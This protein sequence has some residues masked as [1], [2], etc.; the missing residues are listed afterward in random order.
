MS[1]STRL[2]YL[3]ELYFKGICSKEEEDELFHLVNKAQHDEALKNLM[4]QAWV[5]LSSDYQLNNDQSERILSGILTSF[6]SQRKVVR[7]KGVSILYRSAAAAALVILLA[8]GWF[9]SMRYNGKKELPAVSPLAQ[10]ESDALPGGNKAVLI[11]GNGSS[12]VLDSV[13]N[14]YIVSQGGVQVTKLNGQVS[15]SGNEINTAAPVYNTIITP[16]GGIFRVTLPDNS[17]VWLNASSSL[18]FPTVFNGAERQ[19]ELTGEAYFEIA[20]NEDKPF[21]V[22]V[23]GVQVKVLGTHFNIMAY[24]NDPVVK[25]TLLEGAVKV[26]KGES[27][28]MLKPGQE[29]VINQAGQT[30]IKVNQ[31]DMQA[32]MAWKNGLFVFHNANLQSV[33]QEIT[34]WYDVESVYPGNNDVY[35][36]G[37][38]SRNTNLS[39]VLHML[40]VTTDIRFKIEGK[41]IMVI[42]QEKNN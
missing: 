3:F 6:S 16:R 13:D 17:E 30:S 15:Y 11:L 29:A 9:W 36:N 26:M 23:N 5:R 7:K 33:M 40:E 21:E 31:A 14:G 1:E 20:K 10:S 27:E 28:V 37:M 25:T 2:E 12:V 22:K 39:Q 35:L 41:K 42:S 8:G 34:R 32:V 4:D 38:I 24:D 19:V 18:R